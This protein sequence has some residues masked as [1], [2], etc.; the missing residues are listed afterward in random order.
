MQWA[1][2]FIT[3]PSSLPPGI[4]GSQFLH[5]SLLKVVVRGSWLM[6]YN[7]EVH[8]GLNWLKIP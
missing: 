3:A 8:K 2:V 5:L 7:K 6:E 4:P 1:A